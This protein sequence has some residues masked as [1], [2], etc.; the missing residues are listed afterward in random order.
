VKLSFWGFLQGAIGE[1]VDEILKVL[2]IWITPVFPAVFGPQVSFEFL[3]FSGNTLRLSPTSTEEM[4]FCP[5][6][7]RGECYPPEVILDSRLG[8]S[9]DSSLN[10]C[11]SYF[12]LV[13]NRQE[14]TSD[15][16]MSKNLKAYMLINRSN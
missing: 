14:P 4:E 3:E 11:Q 8:D 5:A 12:L 9:S 15:I 13:L 6:C 1:N 16:Q 10:Q 7:G 2:W